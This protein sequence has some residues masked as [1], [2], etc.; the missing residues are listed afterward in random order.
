MENDVH[1]T[2]IKHRKWGVEAPFSGRKLIMLFVPL[3]FAWQAIAQKGGSGP[4]YRLHIDTL[5]IERDSVLARVSHYQDDVVTSEVTA[6][7]FPDTVT[8][9]RYKWMA[10]RP[11]FKSRVALTRLLKHGDDIEYKTDGKKRV[12]RFHYGRLVTMGYFDREDK[13]ITRNAYDPALPG[14]GDGEYIKGEVWI[15]AGNGKAAGQ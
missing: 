11:I 15:Y 10:L 9:P 12:I 7:L 1:R 5:S 14:R 2:I 3:L 4:V 6:F 8:M 13:E